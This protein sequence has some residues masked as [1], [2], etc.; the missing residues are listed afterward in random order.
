MARLRRGIIFIISTPPKGHGNGGNYHDC[1]YTAQAFLDDDDNAFLTYQKDG[2]FYIAAARASQKW[3]DWRVIYHDK[4]P[5]MSET[6]GDHYRWKSEG[7]LSL[8]L[9]GA[10]KDSSL[11][12]CVFLT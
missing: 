6:L 12:R 3:A 2:I 1:W 8:M 11:R 5:Y 9:Q 4:G 10:P 7:V